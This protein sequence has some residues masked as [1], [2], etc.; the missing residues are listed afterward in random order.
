[1]RHTNWIYPI[2][3]IVSSGGRIAGGSDWT[4]SSL[5]PLYAI[6][7]AITRREPGSK[8]GDALIPEEAVD[9]E[10]ILHAYTL[11]GAYSLFKENDIGSL[12]TG[13]LADIVIL[14]R[15]LSQIP[16]NEIHKA[17]VDLTIFDGKIVYERD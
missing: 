5:N 4:V 16:K 9:L 3:S 8:Y 7:V 1:M 11:E 12:E 15:N 10:T 13:K 2:N 6:E 17:L 14:D